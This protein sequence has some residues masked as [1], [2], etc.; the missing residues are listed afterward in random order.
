MIATNGR[1]RPPKRLMPLSIASAQANACG[2]LA[3]ASDSDGLRDSV[4]DGE[5]TAYHVVA[6]AWY[7]TLDGFK[8]KGP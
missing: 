7:A 6:G 5:N 3:V 4:L 2:T 1:I 8:A